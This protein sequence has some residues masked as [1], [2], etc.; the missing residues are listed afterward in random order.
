RAPSLDWLLAKFQTS[1][2]IGSTNEA[3]AAVVTL[4]VILCYAA[5]LIV[6][7]IMDRTLRPDSNWHAIYY[8]AATVTIFVFLNAAQPDFIYFRF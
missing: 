3:V 2:A 6:K 5:P 8:V 7:H 4:S 1:P